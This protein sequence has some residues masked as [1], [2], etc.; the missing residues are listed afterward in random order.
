MPLITGMYLLT[1]ALRLF[2]ARSKIQD[3]FYVV[4]LWFGGIILLPY[5]YPSVTF[6][7]GFPG[8]VVTQVLQFSG[9]F[10]LGSL[11]MR[12]KKI[13]HAQFL[14]LVLILFGV[15]GAILATVYL[16]PRP[17]VDLRFFDYVSPFI[18]A[19][20]TGVFLWFRAK[21][22][23][24][25]SPIITTIADASF[26]VIFVHELFNLFFWHNSQNPLH[27]MANL[28]YVGYDFIR[29]FISFGLALSVVYLLRKIRA[30]QNLLF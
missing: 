29:A 14:S 12:I 27:F 11:L 30:L 10:L 17:P 4:L 6:S 13:D 1:P 2:V 22:G 8:S 3:I 20:S 19:L 26:G 15:I 23:G 18:V 21:F 5:L 24:V 16:N 9:Y 28:S 25:S 7:P